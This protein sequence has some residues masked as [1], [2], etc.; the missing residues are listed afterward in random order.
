MK[1]FINKIKN[2]SSR[3]GAPAN[4]LASQSLDSLVPPSASLTPAPSASSFQSTPNTSSLVLSPNQPPTSLTPSSDLLVA[5][6][7]TTAN[8]NSLTSSTIPT[9]ITPIELP[10][11]PSSKSAAKQIAKNVFKTT[12]VLTKEALAGVPIPAQGV[13]NAVI[14]I[15]EIAEV[16]RQNFPYHSDT[17]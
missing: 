14:K 11:A 9:T 2:P 5:P 8:T 10:P 7:S 16:R 4:P 6:S 12:L 17:Y 13:L 1:G 3:L 15:I